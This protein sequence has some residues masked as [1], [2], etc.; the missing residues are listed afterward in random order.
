MRYK[1]PT[2][3]SKY[4]LPRPVYRHAVTFCECYKTW[5][6]DIIDIDKEAPKA[7]DYTTDKIKADAGDPTAEKAMKRAALQKKVEIID[8]AAADVVKS[9]TLRQFIIL[10]ITTPLSY[11]DLTTINI[12]CGRRQYYQYRREIIYRIA[13]EL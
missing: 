1:A 7:I 11:E 6:D 12:P 2:K 13:K 10:G 4:Y 3:R 8:R 5:R 9:E